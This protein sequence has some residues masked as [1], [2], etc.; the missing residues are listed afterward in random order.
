MEALNRYRVVVIGMLLAVGCGGGGGG[1]PS[2]GEVVVGPP[3]KDQ[4]SIVSGSERKKVEEQLMSKMAEM[5]RRLAA[6]QAQAP[7]K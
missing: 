3:P 2:G 6:I 1:E 7:K 4:L 5:D